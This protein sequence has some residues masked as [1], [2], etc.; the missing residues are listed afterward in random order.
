MASYRGLVR[1]DEPSVIVNVVDKLTE[2]SMVVV[3]VFDATLE[4]S[5]LECVRNDKRRDPGCG[6][7]ADPGYLLY[8]VDADRYDS[9]TGMFHFLSCGS[10]GPWIELFS[11]MTEAE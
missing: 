7:K 5:F 2:Q 11:E 4:S 8:V 6:V 9:P 10:D 1:I 3:F